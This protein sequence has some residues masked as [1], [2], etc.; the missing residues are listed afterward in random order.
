MIKALA[1]VKLAAAHVNIK[2][3]A[4]AKDIGSTIC[5]AAQEIVEG[6]F[7]E[8]CPLLVW[9]TGSDTQT[10]M[11]INDVIANRAIQIIGE[12]IGSKSPVHPNDH[13]NYGQSSNDTFPTAMHIAVAKQID[14]LLI[15]NMQSYI[16]H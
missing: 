7:D 11:N 13:I 2:H 3:G 12:I 14:D 4:I 16:K 10:N 8:E 1:I 15:P 9:Q 5:K 6:K